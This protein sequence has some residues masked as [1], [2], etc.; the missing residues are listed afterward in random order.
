MKNKIL[1]SILI[2][3]LIVAGLLVWQ[4]NLSK[5][6]IQSIKENRNDARSFLSNHAPDGTYLLSQ[7]TE[8]PLTINGYEILVAVYQYKGK[9]PPD[10]FQP[11]VYAFVKKVGSKDDY[12]QSLVTYLSNDGGVP[13]EVLAI[14]ENSFDKKDS[15]KIGL[16]TRW[17]STSAGGNSVREQS[18]QFYEVLAFTIEQ[19]LTF[20]PFENDVTK[21]LKD[22]ECTTFNRDNGPQDGNVL[23][24]ETS[25]IKDFASVQKRLMD[26][27]IKTISSNP[28]TGKF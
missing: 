3:V 8:T 7:F 28:D 5:I 10:D 21:A 25:K 19:D 9:L 11:T 18:G 26:L 1:G 27:G 13:T 14:F 23:K 20:L 4:R 22:C 16:L 6:P 17:D 12:K 24:K 15:Q 2:V